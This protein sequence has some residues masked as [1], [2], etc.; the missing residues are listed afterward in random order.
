M[1][2]LLFPVALVAC[3]L[4]SIL[5]QSIAPSNGSLPAAPGASQLMV[6]VKDGGMI[7]AYKIDALTPP[8]GEN[9][10]LSVGTFESS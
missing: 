7:M 5:A 1:M 8:A 2:L 6:T 10:L 4:P 9:D 3:F